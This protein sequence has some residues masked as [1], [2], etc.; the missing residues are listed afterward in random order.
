MKMSLFVSVFCCAT[1]YSLMAQAAC[2][3]APSCDA[4]GYTMTAAD[5][6]GQ[7]TVKCPT[8]TS[9]IFCKKAAA[10]KPQTELPILY[11]DGT[12]SKDIISGKTPIGIVFDEAA[13]LAVSLVDIKESHPLGS[14]EME[15]A[16]S[17]SCDVW[18]LVN[19][20]YDYNDTTVDS[21]STDGR[22]NTY[23]IL[24]NGSSCNGRPAAS[25]VNRYKPTGC[26]HG[27]CGQNNWFLPSIKEL[28]DI[29]K[30]KMQI[31]ASLALLSS[32][33]A[34]SLIDDYYWSSLERNNYEAWGLAMSDGERNYFDKNSQDHYVRAVVY[35]G[36]QKTAIPILYGDG[37]V[38]KNLISGKTPIGL[39][40]DETNR[41][42]MALTDV[43]PDGSA[44]DKVYIAW[45]NK[46][47]DIPDLT[48]CKEESTLTTCSPDGRS[49]TDKI[50][51][52]GSGCGGTPAATAVNNYQPTGCT[53]DF[54]KKSK[55]FIPSMRDLVNIC[56]L[57]SQMEISHM[58]LDNSLEFLRRNGIN[59]SGISYLE[60]V[61]SNEESRGLVKTMLLHNRGMTNS[62]KT[63][64]HFVRPVL[65]Y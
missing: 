13:K 30:L 37:T 45:S 1:S 39:V 16:T 49:N 41:L 22:L 42:A 2:V 48:N 47:Y 23:Q 24:A 62:Y 20:T 32:F 11:G 3:P 51:A 46:S 43:A 4:L 5:C 64:V 36:E 50:L 38:S 28:S 10:P 14:K 54:C 55:W 17:S 35:Y 31:N 60:Y 57:N 53:K 15:W 21:C 18:G 27:L 56:T 29:Y 44:G 9:K 8:D 25:A 19:C 65:A 63:D 61:S 6:N 52:C 33:G 58:M 34:E 59:T 7:I 12:V 26:T 40:F